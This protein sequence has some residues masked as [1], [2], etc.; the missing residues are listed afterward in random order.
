MTHTGSVDGR[1]PLFQ[2]LD[3]LLQEDGTVSIGELLDQAGEQVYGLTLLLLALVTFIPGV[4]NGI[5]FATLGIGLQMAWGSPHP[6]LP[7]WAQKHEMRRGRIKEFLAKVEAG[8]LRLG[9]RTAPRRRPNQRLL[10]LAV[11]WTA[12]L[13]LLPLPLPM[14]NV[15]PAISLVLLGLALVEE[16]LFLLWLGLG[17]SLFATIYFAFFIREAIQAIQGIWHWIAGRL[18]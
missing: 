5:S 2:A 14:A 15:L 3:R 10:G 16:W 7:R 1:S 11:A 17:G 13:A 6:W 18:G 4:A 8:M 9:K 12:F